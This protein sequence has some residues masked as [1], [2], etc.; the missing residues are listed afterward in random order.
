MG[1]GARRR[2]R[3]LRRGHVWA[4]MAPDSVEESG[5]AYL[6]APGGDNVKVRDEMMTLLSCVRPISPVSSVLSRIL[7]V[8]F[9]LDADAARTVFQALRTAAPGRAVHRAGLG[10]A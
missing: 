3:V 6:V 2:F 8:L 7:K 10:R 1:S 5:R 4:E 9:P